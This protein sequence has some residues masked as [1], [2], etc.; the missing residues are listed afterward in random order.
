MTVITVRLFEYEELKA[1]LNPEDGIAVFSCDNCAR[2]CDGLGGEQGLDALAGKLEADGFSVVCRQL[3]PALC[4]RKQ[5]QARLDDEGVK[6]ELARVDVILPLACQMGIDRVKELL[7][8]L[9]VLTI[10][11]TLGKGRFSPET[12]ARLTRPSADLD[13]AVDDAAGIPIQE[14]ASRLGL[15]AGSF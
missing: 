4:S 7:P 10:T 13:I 1:R 14:A 9:T 6:K 2:R 12:G 5:V 8:G 11:K 3:F 15:F